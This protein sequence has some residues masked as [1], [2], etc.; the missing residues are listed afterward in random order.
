M[1]GHERLFLD[2]LFVQAL[3][4]RRDRYHEEAKRLAPRLH[5]AR[6][7]WVT[8][9][10]FLELGAALSAIDRD[11][12]AQFI[13]LA[14]STSNIRVVTVDTSLLLRSLSLFEGR[15]DKEWSLADCISFT[16]MEEEG[17]QL[18]LTADMHFQQA[19]FQAVMSQMP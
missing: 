2:T 11:G 4:N 10:I 18:A 13:R 14:Y 19:G 17:L 12:V 15:P 8:E 6:E 16:V 9:A 7:V 1:P 3:I 5:A